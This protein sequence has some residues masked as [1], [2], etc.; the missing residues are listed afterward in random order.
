[1]RTEARLNQTL[2]GNMINTTQT[3]NCQDNLTRMSYLVYILAELTVG[4]S[5]VLPAESSVRKLGH[6]A[7]P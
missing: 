3:Q 6:L 5:R 7:C 1:M 4:D 2:L